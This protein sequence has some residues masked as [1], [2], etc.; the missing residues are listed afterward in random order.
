MSAKAVNVN[1]IIHHNDIS[2]LVG[3][4][5]VLN[6]KHAFKIKTKEEILRSYKVE[7]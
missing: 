6:Y 7:E 2:E 5:V 4:Y 3:M 1:D